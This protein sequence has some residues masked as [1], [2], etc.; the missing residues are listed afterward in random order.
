VTRVVT[1]RG[2]QG[3][4]GSSDT[5]EPN[6][7]KSLFDYSDHTGKFIENKLVVKLNV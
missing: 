4:Y 6:K 7:S 3:S 1:V 5:F 2:Y